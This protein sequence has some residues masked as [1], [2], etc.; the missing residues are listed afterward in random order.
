MQY[1]II[2][3]NRE[4]YQSIQQEEFETDKNL[5]DQVSSISLRTYLTRKNKVFILCMIKPLTKNGIISLSEL[6]QAYEY[7]FDEKLTKTMKIIISTL[8]ETLVN[9]S[10][11]YTEDIN[12]D[13]EDLKYIAPRTRKNVNSI[14]VK[15]LQIT[16]KNALKRI[17]ALD[18]KNKLGIENFVG[19]N[20]TKFRSNCKNPKLRNIYFRLIHNDLFTHVRMKKYR[21]TVTDECPRCGITETS[22][23][24]LWECAHV[25]NI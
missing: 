2:D 6:I 13:N 25:K 17:D 15:E 11:C 23:H 21:M 22:K 16:L 14:T 7:E 10:K 18:V 5:I 1:I 4:T 9:I 20:I 12:S 19:E 3:Y 8:P 24:L